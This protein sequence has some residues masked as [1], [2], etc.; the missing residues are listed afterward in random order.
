MR[1]LL[2]ALLVVLV[3]FG[4]TAGWPSGVIAGHTNDEGLWPTARAE[5]QVHRTPPRVWIRQGWDVAAVTCDG[6]G[7]GRTRGARQVYRNFSCEIIVVKP[8]NDC[9]SSGIY[10]CVAAFEAT[11]L[12][13]R[14][15]VIDRWRYALYRQP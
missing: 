14:L 4:V 2:T 15:H 1:G 9:H 5:T 6:L 3:G 8:S 10:F 11:A 13:R 12:Q 7:R